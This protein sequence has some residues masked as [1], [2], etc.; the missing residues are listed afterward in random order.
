MLVPDRQTLPTSGSEKSDD[1]HLLFQY[2]Y[3]I[4]NT[5]VLIDLLD[6]ISNMRHEYLEEVSWSEYEDCAGAVSS[7]PWPQIVSIFC[8]TAEARNLIKLT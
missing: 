8:A 5:I 1:I 4:V 2:V 3:M 7:L 6:D